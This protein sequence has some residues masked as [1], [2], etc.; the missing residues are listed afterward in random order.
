[1]KKLFIIGLLSVLCVHNTFCWKVTIINATN[2]NAKVEAR[3]GGP[4]LFCKTDRVD[5][6]KGETRVI[7]AKE[8]LLTHLGAIITEAFVIDSGTHIGDITIGKE[9]YP[10]YTDAGSGKSNQGGRGGR[11]SAQQAIQE[12][13]EEG[14]SKESP[15]GKSAGVVATPYTSSGQRAYQTFYLIGPMKDDKDK[16]SAGKYMVARIVQ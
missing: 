11:R 12:G 9:V 14:M 5:I 13:G 7:D 4:A 2:G 8:C 16:E 15:R 1:M 6:P 3:W 10:L